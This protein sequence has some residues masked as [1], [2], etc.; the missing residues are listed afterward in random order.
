M[1]ARQAGDDMRPVEPTPQPDRSPVEPDPQTRLLQLGR[2]AATVAAEV[3]Q[4]LAVIRNAVVFL[5][6]HLGEHLDEKVR[7]HMSLVWH[8]TEAANDSVTELLSFVETQSPDPVDVDINVL[9]VDAL[10]RVRIPQNVSAPS[11]MDDFLPAI[12]V[13]PMQIVRALTRILRNAFE[14]MPEGGTVEVR[15]YPE[16]SGVVVT[17]HDTGC[18]IAPEVLPQVAEPLF[19]TKPGAKGLGLTVARNLIELNHGTLEIQ[20]PAGKGTTCILRFPVSGG[21]ER[22]AGN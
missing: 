18:G 17:V 7:K 11:W 8:S 1:T 16:E 22:T 5:N 2:I 6:M 4:P 12:R 20:S 15:G 9:V 10:S 14:A 21:S 13:D 3:K 19:T